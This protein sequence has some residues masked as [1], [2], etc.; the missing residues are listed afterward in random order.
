MVS[1]KSRPEIPVAAVPN[2]GVTDLACQGVEEVKLVAIRRWLKSQKRR[3]VHWARRAWFPLEAPEIR[4]DFATIDLDLTLMGEGDVL[5]V[6][7]RRG[8]EDHDSQRRVGQAPLEGREGGETDI[9]FRRMPVVCH[10]LGSSAFLCPCLQNG[11]TY[12]Q[13]S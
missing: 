1:A 13:G 8:A 4:L 6:S 2:F 9:D 7:I 11:T 12:V 5:D 10:G 3:D